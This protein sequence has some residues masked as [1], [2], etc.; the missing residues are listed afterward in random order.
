VGPY[1]A[2]KAD[3]SEYRGDYDVDAEHL[4]DFHAERLRLLVEPGPDLLAIETIPTAFETRAIAEA[5]GAIDAIP[6]WLAFVCRDETHTAGG[7]R[8]EDAVA[9]AIEVPGIVA[10]GVNCTDPRYIGGLLERAATVTDLPLIAYA[11]G[12]QHWNAVAGQWEGAPVAADDPALVSRWLEAG[13]R[14]VGGCCGVG[15]RDI[16]GLRERRDL[17]FAGFGV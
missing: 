14:I 5:V 2:T 6:S 8:I 13:A 11:N 3:G 9:A 12:G 10:V 15:P 1:G 4:R 16:A 17:D 7:D